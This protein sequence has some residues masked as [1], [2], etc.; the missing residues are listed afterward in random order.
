MY[1]RNKIPHTLILLP[2]PVLLPLLDANPQVV[3]MPVPLFLLLVPPLFLQHSP[4][5]FL[6]QLQAI[7]RQEHVRQ[8]I[9]LQG[10][11]LIVLFVGKLVEERL[12]KRGLIVVVFGRVGSPRG[13]T[14]QKHEILLKDVEED[15]VKA[16]PLMHSS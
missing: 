11:P 13:C 8:Q 5:C 6:Q 15:F 3:E 14:S 10:T 1:I 2:L 16:M 12:Q 9:V 4:L 7:R